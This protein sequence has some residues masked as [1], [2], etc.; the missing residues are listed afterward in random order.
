ME[1]RILYECIGLTGS[2]LIALSMTMRHIKILRI[3]NLAGCVFFAAYG[4]MFG[5][6]SVT[7]LNIF[8]VAVN[9]IF[10]INFHIENSRSQSFDVLFKDPQVDEYIRRF[11]IYHSRDIIRFFPTFD[12]DPETGTLSN[13]ECCFILRQTLPVSLVAFRRE[14]PDKITVV[15]DYAVPAYRDLKNGKFFFETAVSQI[16]SPGTIFTATGEVPAHS[17][18]LKKL[19]FT[20]IAEDGK[21]KHFSKEFKG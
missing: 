7:L 15:L 18:Y 11:I 1:M 3:V 21:G 10:L 20:E 19:G 8:T 6:L 9:I 13:T 5:S 16:A 17:S 2:L 14:S 12:P 4:I